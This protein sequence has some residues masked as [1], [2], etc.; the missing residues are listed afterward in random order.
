MI[1]TLAVLGG[2]LCCAAW[3]WFGVRFGDAV[4]GH[5][6]EPTVPQQ[7]VKTGVDWQ[8]WSADR[9][10]EAAASGKL[11]Y[12]YLAPPW[13]GPCAEMERTSFNDSRV[14]KMLT[15]R[16]VPI[17]VDPMQRPEI[18]SR[19]LLGAF[20]SGL[21]L[22]SA[23]DLVGGGGYLPPDSLSYLLDNVDQMWRYDKN[24]IDDQ[25]AKLR[26][27]FD[28][29]ADSLMRSGPANVVL[30]KAEAALEEHYDSVYGGFGTQPKLA[31]HDVNSFL[32]QPYAPN[33]RPLYLKIAEHTLQAQR[34]IMD[35]VW[36]GLFRYAR[37]DDWT[38]PDHAKLLAD[39]APAARNYLDA[40]NITGDS[41]YL[42]TA[43]SLL[44]YIDE[45]LKSDRGWGFYS[46]QQAELISPDSIISG[47][48]YF[49]LSD[50]ERRALGMP[51]IDTSF[52]TR[53][54]C[55]AVQAYLQAAAV[56]ELPAYRDYALATLNRIC[57]GSLRPNGSV[58]H[59]LRNHSAAAAGLLRDQV[60]LA[61]ALLDAYE[62]TG[63][64][65]YLKLAKQVVDYTGRNLLDPHNG[66]LQD[67]EIEAA[68]VG[69]LDTPLHPI[70]IN[71]EA[72]IMLMRLH[73]I[74]GER[75][76]LE[77]ASPVL[78][79]VFRKPTIVND[80]RFCQLSEAWLWY[81]H[82][83]I[84]L[85][86]VGKPGPRADEIM[87]Q[88]AHAHFPRSVMIHLVP[89]EDELKVARFPLE[90]GDEP[91]LYVAQ[92]VVLSEPITAEDDV[93]A[94]ILEFMKSIPGAVGN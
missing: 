36:G 91:R 18:S 82:Y 42:K 59:N 86:L 4:S 44:G 41:L 50:A 33:G 30:K 19:Y 27:E 88:L 94:R 43:E 76:Y 92:Q 6:V 47:E 69:R 72:I 81:S 78:S 32:F 20:P 61:A 40:F 83:P 89:G 63:K 5:S 13:C 1:R 14:I 71:C 22:T 66:G 16:Y 57:S 7:L 3:F 8:P 79:Y 26:A 51:T 34:Q 48:E 73:H 90:A 28:A 31:L 65:N 37:F 35:P 54:N 60:A 39:N 70:D 52:Y 9:F 93:V 67:I 84:K 17:L 77:L 21:I 56:L 24:L 11:V 38:R 74:T 46:G 64:Q 80:L 12:L 45:F 53:E 29:R 23:G 25:A 85:A 2:L 15:D 58:Y 68:A 10:A 55:L 87:R 75:T 49:S 62:A